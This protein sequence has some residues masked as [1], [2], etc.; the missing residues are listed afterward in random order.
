M[1]Y[2]YKRHATSRMWGQAVTSRDLTED[3]YVVP[4]P[5]TELN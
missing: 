5:T 3:N 2:Y 4:L 1:F